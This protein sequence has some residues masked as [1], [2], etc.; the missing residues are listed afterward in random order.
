MAAAMRIERLIG[1]LGLA[2]I[3]AGCAPHIAAPDTKFAA[4]AYIHDQPPMTAQGAGGDWWKG[5]HNPALD[6]LVAAGLTKNPAIASQNALVAQAQSQAVAADG[7]F[8]PQINLNPNLSRQSYPTGPNGFPPYTIY[9]LVGNISYNP[10]LFG[11]ASSVFRN[12]KALVA[13]QKAQAQ[14]AALALA[15]NIVTSVI[16]RAGI[17]AQIKTTQALAQSEH[18]LLSVLQGEYQAGAIGQLPMLQ[19]QAEYQ[20][21]LASLPGLQAQESVQ[22]HRLAILTGTLPADFTAPAI[23]LD[24]FALPAAAPIEMPSLLVATRPDIVAARALVAARYA[25]LGSATAAL[26]PNLTLSAQGGYAAE[27][28]NTLFEP[29]SALWTL[30]GNL[31]APLFNGFTLSANRN[32]ARHALAASLA[33]YRTTVLGAFEQVADG[34]RNL[35]FD[36]LAVQANQQAAQTAQAAYQL[37]QAQYRLGAADYT[38]VLSAEIAR[39]QA[40]LRL[41]QARTQYALDAALLDAAVA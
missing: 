18:D 40:D 21:T 4:R 7:S 41:I 29:G 31:I 5:F 17:I 24:D 10:G 20:T 39:G 11:A 14:G 6:A 1:A 2:G 25:A 27:T 35:Q 32:A 37:A 16:T 13:Y 19:Q 34:L 38:T 3:L 12:G 9:S 30:A 33:D 15:G 26:Y 23:T 28:L 36:A 8:L 22:S